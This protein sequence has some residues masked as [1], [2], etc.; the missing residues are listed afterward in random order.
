MTGKLYR[1]FDR[2]ADF[3]ERHSRLAAFALLAFVFLCALAQASGKPFWYDELCTYLSAALP[4]W[5][6]VWNFYATGVDIPSPLPSLIAHAMLHFSSNPELVARLP[7]ML[8]F[9]V[10]CLCMFVFMR[11]RY[12]AGYALTVLLAP[13]S[14]PFFFFYSSE[15]RAYALVLAS[16]GLAMVCWQRGVQ[17][18][19]HRAVTNWSLFGLWFALAFAICAHPFAIFLLVPFALAQLAADL[20][21]KKPEFRVW[22]ALLLSPLGVLP[23]LHGEMLASRSYRGTFFSRPGW[24]MVRETSGLLLSPIAVCG[25][26]LLFSILVLV[27]SRKNTPPG[28]SSPQSGLTWPE[29]VFAISLALMPAYMML[30]CI[31]LGVYRAPYVLSALIGIVLCIV[32]ALAELS[33]RQASLGAALLVALLLAISVR[34]GSFRWHALAHPTRVHAN[35]IREYDRQAWVKT[36]AASSLPVTI[37]DPELYVQARYYWP[38]ALQQRLWYPTSV[39]MFPRYPGSVTAQLTIMH[40]GKYFDLHTMDWAAFSARHPHFLLVTGSPQDAWLDSYLTHLSSSRVR[41]ELLGSS[42]GAPAVYDVQLL[43]PAAP[44]LSM[45]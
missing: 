14:L 43:N 31:P 28:G 32:A 9:C 17:P 6:G 3:L 30:A 26:M 4:G 1:L 18:S 35:F 22:I 20:Q 38:A 19:S 16:A 13:V 11:R 29:T 8:A 21:R 41:I 25:A 23:I 24:H 42:F 37:A 33:N 34:V 15:L 2:A 44:Q 40:T 10:M 12:P 5:S 7:F 39:A 36:V 45:K 27:M